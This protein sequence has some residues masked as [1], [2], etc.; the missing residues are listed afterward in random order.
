MSAHEAA[1]H[2]SP[3][4]SLRTPADGA[5]LVVQ[6]DACLP[7]TQC[8]QCGYAG[9]QPYAEA[10][11]RQAADINQCPPGGEAT[12]HALAALLHRPPR[13]LNPLHGV[14][15]SEKVRAVINEAACIGCTL[16]IQACPV[17]AIVGAAR[18][19]HTVI[20]DAC[21]GCALCLPPCPVDCIALQA[22]PG[23]SDAMTPAESQ[24]ARQWTQR[25]Q[26]RLAKQSTPTNAAV[27]ETAPGLPAQAQPSQPAPSLDAVR[28]QL[29]QSALAAARA[30]VRARS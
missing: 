8:Q 22:V 11:A 1:S 20:A 21:T 25:R 28:Q 17:D 24:L 9:C 14:I 5:T 15:P 7:Q 27:A 29:K 23:R 2:H 26:A 3:P 12:I 16:C 30:R 18:L 4:T 6:I 19:M 10:I 13:P